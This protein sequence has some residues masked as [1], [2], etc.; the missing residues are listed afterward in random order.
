MGS[1]VNEKICPFLVEELGLAG[2]DERV[3]QGCPVDLD[4]G[5]D[6]S[7]DLTTGCYRC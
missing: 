4:A 6:D 3:G 5:H 2:R 1:R 7:P